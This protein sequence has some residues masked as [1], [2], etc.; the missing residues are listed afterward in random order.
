MIYPQVKSYQ[1]WFIYC[2]ETIQLVSPL[3]NTHRL[4]PALRK[5][6]HLALAYWELELSNA[7]AKKRLILIYCANI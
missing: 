3:D 5:H 6:C 1:Y 4:L 2:R 7:L